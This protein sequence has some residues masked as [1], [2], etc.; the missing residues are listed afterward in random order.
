MTNLRKQ[1]FQVLRAFAILAALLIVPVVGSAYTLVMRDGRRL[2]IPE[3]F[4]LTKTTLT[5]EVSPGFQISILM[6]AI[7]VAATEQ[8]NGASP[9]EFFRRGQIR[10]ID[11]SQRPVVG[12][13]K[14]TITNR[15]LQ[16]Y[17][18]SR[19]ENEAA[20]ERRRRELGL[21]SMAESR[22][23][24]EAEAELIRQE[25][26][27]RRLQATEVEN[28]W[29]SR[30]A[31]LRAEI[32]ATDAEISYIR[33]RLDEVTAYA[34]SS[35][36]TVVTSVLPFGSVGR[37]GFARSGLGGSFGNFRSGRPATFASPGPG[38]LTTRSG[39]RGGTVRGGFGFRAGSFGRGQIGLAPPFLP[40]QNLTSFSDLNGTYDG[41]YERSALVVRLDGLVGHR[42]GLRARWR[43]LEEE[44]RRAGASPGWLRP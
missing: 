26:D 29:R 24:R 42:A 10:T 3:R 36:F 31:D 40:F 34:N 18:N 1:G 22:R 44:A 43:D 27:E 17:A 2:Q 5:Y 21:P 14:R 37:S 6:A 33:I 25:L 15:E 39:F 38:L 16:S 12:K 4:S 8:A 11:T 30:G 35:S 23:K 28:Y 7:N 41:G 32:A 20:Y 9:G 13:A 19:I